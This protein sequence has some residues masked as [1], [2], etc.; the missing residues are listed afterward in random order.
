MYRVL[1]IQSDPPRKASYENVGA[2]SNHIGYMQYYQMSIREAE[3]SHPPSRLH[4]SRS[5]LL[6]RVEVTVGEP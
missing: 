5:P 1:H 2:R 3:S 4:L 6:D